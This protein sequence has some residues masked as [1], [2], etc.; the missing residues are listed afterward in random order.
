MAEKA[1]EFA[2]RY[3]RPATG[4]PPLRVVGGDSVVCPFCRLRFLSTRAL[5]R[6]RTGTAGT[7]RCLTAEEC[8][9]ADILVM[10]PSG[11]SPAA[12]V[13]EVARPRAQAQGKRAR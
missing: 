3:G 12:P 7:R 8:A 9:E 11:G 6:H 5:L 1:R 10:E 13:A 2:L 4:L